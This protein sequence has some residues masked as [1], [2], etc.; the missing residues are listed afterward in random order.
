MYVLEESVHRRSK[1]DVATA[2]RKNRIEREKEMF[3]YEERTD[4][5]ND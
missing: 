3:E 5:S 4:K 1:C 2:E